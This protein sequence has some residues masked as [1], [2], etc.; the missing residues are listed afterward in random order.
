MHPL[1]ANT[2]AI[3][4]LLPALEAMAPEVDRVAARLGDAL[5]NG[6]K[7]L[8][9]GN[10]GSA[11]DAAHITTEFVVRFVKDRKPYPAICLN[12]H[13]GDL[14]ATS[15]DY[16]YEHVFERQVN[17]FGQ[18]GDVLIGLSTSGNSETVRRALVAGKAAGLYTVAMLGRDG[19]KTKGLSDVDLIVPHD[20]TARIQEAHQ[21]LLHTICQIVDDRLVAAE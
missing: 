2:A 17:A 20:V 16:G 19:G 1:L 8:A 5:L 10:G 3:R 18:P 14:T 7:L 12:A 4:E 6:G 9:C 15:N 11:A 21:L 13:G